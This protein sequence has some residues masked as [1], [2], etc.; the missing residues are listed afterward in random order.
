ME[1]LRCVE[2]SCP[3]NIIFDRLSGIHGAQQVDCLKEE[4][5]GKLICLSCKKNGKKCI[6]CCLSENLATENGQGEFRATEGE[7]PEVWRCWSCYYNQQD[8]Y[9]CERC[10]REWDGNAQC[11]CGLDYSSDEEYNDGEVCNLKEILSEM[12]ELMYDVKGDMKEGQYLRMMNYM[13][14]LNENL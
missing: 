8:F 2:C 11:P 9:T 4:H 7:W 14:K 10:G 3:E 1:E 12:M 5:D 6:D 13:K